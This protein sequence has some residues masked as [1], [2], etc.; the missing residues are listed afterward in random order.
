M[1]SFVP[2]F[3]LAICVGVYFMYESPSYSNIQTLTTE[4][5]NYNQVLQEAKD[6]SAKRD[7]ILAS[8]NAISTD[9]LA[10]LSK[11]VP[12][13]F[14][15]VIFVNHLNTIASKYGL[16]LDKMQI[17]EQNNTGGQ[18]IAPDQ[19]SYNTQNVSFSVKGQYTTFMNFLKDLESGLY[20][21]D[22]TGLSIKKG[23]L[24]K[25]GQSFE[26]DVSTNTYSLN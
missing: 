10:R 22:I 19:N 2:F 26:F 21:V 17:V 24:D 3:I 1:K 6:V 13:N 7:Q 15:S 14:N 9:N 18:V 11:I 12:A 20:L 25:T 8:Y 5:N 23:T 16:V 4:K